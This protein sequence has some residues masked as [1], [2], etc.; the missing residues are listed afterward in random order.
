M[1]KHYQD[2]ALFASLIDAGS[3]TEAA[4]RFDLPKSRVSQRVQALEE[5]LG[6]RLLNRT[7]RRL[8]LTSAGEKYLVYCQQILAVGT[9]ADELIQ[10][11]TARPAG[12]LRVIAPAGLMMESL[13]KW[14][15]SFLKANPEVTLE[16]LTADSFFESIDGAFDVAFRI[17][18]PV[19]QSYIGRLLGEYE[20]LLVAS[21]EY[22]KNNPVCTVDDLV[23][24][25][26]LTHKTWKHLRLNKEIKKV[27]F[28]DGSRLI[29][30]NLP[31]LLKCTLQGSGISVLPKYLVDNHLDNH[32]LEVVLPDWHVDSIDIW[33]VYP[34]NKNNSPTLNSYVNFILAQY[35]NSAR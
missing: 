4:S 13:L 26:I 10:M 20:R 27:T 15:Q 14:N 28:Q 23:N 25:D 12:K 21:P 8:S 30:D 24:G 33:L 7:T 6:I 29:T 2:M 22:L 32:R 34:S 18:K 5:H 16:I 9:E 3:F 35:R 19:E 17:G 1:Y 11:I 31:Y